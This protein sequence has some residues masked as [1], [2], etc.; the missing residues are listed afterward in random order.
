MMPPTQYVLKITARI[1]W[2]G[3]MNG[4]PEEVHSFVIYTGDDPSLVNIILE[5]EISMFSRYQMMFAQ[6]DQGQIIDLHQ[7][8]QD[9]LAIPFRWI[10]S[11]HATVS[12]LGAELSELDENGV[13][14]F[15]DGSKPLLN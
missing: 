2:E 4:L 1:S 8:P 12:K 5:R 14:R 7:T 6:R 10:V 15:A 3:R 11:F 13:E 9:R